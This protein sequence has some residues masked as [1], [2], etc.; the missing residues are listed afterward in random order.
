[1]KVWSCVEIFGGVMTDMRV[2][3]TMEMARK[4]FHDFVNEN[5]S[6][7]DCDPD[8]FNDG[9]NEYFYW[10]DGFHNDNEIH[11]WPVYIEMED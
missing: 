9:V 8:F 11:I 3:P 5:G 6:I 7:E 1:M 10:D 2:F 4:Y